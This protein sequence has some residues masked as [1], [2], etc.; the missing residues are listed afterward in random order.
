MK[1]FT[2]T[3]A[4]ATGLTL[5]LAAPFAQ[6]DPIDPLPIADI[7]SA[8]FNKLFQPMSNNQVMASPFTFEGSQGS[9]TSGNVVSQVFQGGGPAAGLYAYAY[10]YDLNNAKDSDNAL[11][12]IKATSW[13]FNATPALSD[14]TNTGT[15]VGAYAITDGAIGGIVAPGTQKPTEL[16]FEPN[17]SSGSLLATYFDKTQKIPALQGGRNSATF[18]VLADQPPTTK[19]VSILGTNPV[20]SASPLTTAFSPQNGNLEPVPVPEPATILAWAGMMGAIA[21]VRRVRRGR[22]DLA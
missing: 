12:D 4:L 10:Q 21:L 19:F 6:A 18:V 5:G 3:L 1:T 20:T 13:K 2:K 17:T 7:P 16:N 22:L 9:P 11:V 15:K 8:T 14:L